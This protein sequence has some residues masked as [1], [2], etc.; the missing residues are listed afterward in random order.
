[1][2]EKNDI[3]SKFSVR[4]KILAGILLGAMVIFSV[5]L[6]YQSVSISKTQNM[7]MSY[8]DS[9]SSTTDDEKL[10]WVTPTSQENNDS[11]IVSEIEES[12]TISFYDPDNQEI[13]NQSNG[14]LYQSTAAPTETYSYYQTTY[15]S[16][17]TQTTLPTTQATT[18]LPT[19]SSEYRTYVLN[20]SSKKIH[21]PDCSS[22]S[23]MKA[24]NKRQVTW[25]ENDYRQ[26][27]N[28]GYTPC[29]RCGAG[30]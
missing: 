3:I 18:T 19:V 25:N 8:M 7:L 20:T 6:C 23:T 10:V 24:S 14:F 29:G 30:R 4:E 12:E 22:V 26:A 5:V 17:V 9:Q 28:E 16:I 21:A 13:E 15:E 1:M 2:K 27:L 11:E